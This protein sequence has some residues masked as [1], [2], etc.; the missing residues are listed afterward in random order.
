VDQISDDTPLRSCAI[1][2][3]YPGGRC[4][5]SREYRKEKKGDMC[6]NV[7]HTVGDA[8]DHGI[9]ADAEPTPVKKAPDRRKWCFRC[10][11]W[12]RVRTNESKS[13]LDCVKNRGLQAKEDQYI[14]YALSSCTLP[15]L[16]WA[17]AQRR[18]ATSS[19]NSYRRK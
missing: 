18:R 8:L 12:K 15:R 3:T 10:T 1:P 7:D 19:S 16:L 17:M 4:F 6:E 5:S 11:Y 9:E 14:L 13:S 2:H